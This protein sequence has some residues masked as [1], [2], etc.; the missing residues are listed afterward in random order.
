[1]STVYQIFLIAVFVATSQKNT[2]F[3]R[4][5]LLSSLEADEIGEI[6]VRAVCTAKIPS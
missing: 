1:M 4:G 2:G 6:E 5:P 3:S